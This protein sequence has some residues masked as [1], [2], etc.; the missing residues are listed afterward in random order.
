MAIIF[1]V[2]IGCALFFIMRARTHARQ[3]GQF[4]QQV[5]RQ[6]TTSIQASDWTKSEAE[7]LR[8]FLN[9][10][11]GQLLIQRARFLEAANAIKGANDVFHTQHSAGR[12][13]GFSDAINWLESLASD[14]TISKLS[15]VPATQEQITMDGQ[16]DEAAPVDIRRSF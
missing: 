5:R 16:Q 1:V 11:T 7:I 14:E 2:L 3:A 8:T 12:T 6:N 15:R 13:A 10:P 4:M 9:S